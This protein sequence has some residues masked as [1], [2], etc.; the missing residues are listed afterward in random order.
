MNSRIGFGMMGVLD[1]PQTYLI[2]VVF[3]IAMMGW[4]VWWLGR[5]RQVPFEAAWRKL[6]YLGQ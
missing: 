4:S 1:V 3:F 5:N 6:T 2:G